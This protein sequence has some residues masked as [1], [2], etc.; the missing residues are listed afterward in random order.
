[1]DAAAFTAL[2][3]RT[4]TILTGA[5]LRQWPAAL[6]RNSVD[7]HPAVLLG[8]GGGGEG[9]GGG[10]EGEGGDALE[11]P[12]EPEGLG[13]PLGDPDG[14]AASVMGVKPAITGV[15][16]PGGV[17]QFPACHTQREF[18]SITRSI[19]SIIAAADT[20]RKRISTAS[21]QFLR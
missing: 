20:A 10:G 7:T 9:E 1:M 8:E 12:E 19:E 21:M 16:G 13:D 6:L 15:A 18:V 3:K 14:L 17:V 2:Q 11:L 5:F 4:A